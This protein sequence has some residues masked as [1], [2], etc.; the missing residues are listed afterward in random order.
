M[1]VDFD[2]VIN[3]KEKSNDSDFSVETMLGVALIGAVTSA[4]MYYIY[5]NLSK[6]TKASIREMIVNSIKGK[7]DKL[8]AR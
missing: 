3:E 1:D 7:M 6:D 2:N 4:A 5:S 8:T